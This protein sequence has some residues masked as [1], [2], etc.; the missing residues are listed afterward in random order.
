MEIGGGNSCVIIIDMSNGE[1]IIVVGQDYDIFGG[2]FFVFMGNVIDFDGDLFIYCWEQYDNEVGEVM[3][4]FV[5]N[6]QGLMFWLFD[7]ISSL[8]CYFL[9]L[10]DFVNN[11]DF[12]WEILLEIIC[13]MDFWVIVC[14]FDGIYGCIMEDNIILSV[15]NLVGF[16]FVIVFNINVIWF[17]GL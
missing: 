9:C 7:F 12:I 15:D 4:L 11:V 13:D 10:S 6:I 16:F 5:I 3:F 2:M 17:E 1:F 14:D 8:M